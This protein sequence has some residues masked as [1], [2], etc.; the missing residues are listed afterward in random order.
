MPVK[1]VI[2]V[3]TILIIVLELAIPSKVGQLMYGEPGMYI[4]LAVGCIIFALNFDRL[5]NAIAKSYST[6]EQ[7]AF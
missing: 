7:N 1:A 5:R 3:L 4:G 6:S 2:V